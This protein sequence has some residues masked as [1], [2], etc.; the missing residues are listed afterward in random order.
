MPNVYDQSFYKKQLGGSHIAAEQVAPHIFK[1]FNPKSVID[2]GCGVGPWLKAFNEKCGVTDILGVDG[3]YVDKSML[4]INEDQF[5]SFDLKKVFTPNR[6]YELATC[7]EV[8]EHLPDETSDN[9]VQS[10]VNCSD[11]IAFSAALPG[12]T[13]TYHINEQYPEYWAKKFIAKGYV[14]IDHIR[15][16]IWD[17]TNVDFWYRQNM[18]L[19]IKKDVFESRFKEKLGL[20][21]DRTDP[22]FITRIH[23]E[24]LHYYIGKFNQ[25]KSIV[26]FIRYHL[27]PLKK[28]VR[29]NKK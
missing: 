5:I 15:K 10:L 25:T 3:D 17:L 9:L 8:G 12:Q 28:L 20:S 19:Y 27:Y 26:G 23:P 2:I 1:I 7:F 29:R 18:L 4:Q 21:K 22:E 16:E 6:K 11:C 13:G 14:C 24:M